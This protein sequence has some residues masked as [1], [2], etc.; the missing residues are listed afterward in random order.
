VQTPTVMSL[1]DELI[2][3]PATAVGTFGIRGAAYQRQPGTG[4]VTVVS[5]DPPC[6]I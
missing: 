4:S 3:P 6:W 1:I 2:K 5:A